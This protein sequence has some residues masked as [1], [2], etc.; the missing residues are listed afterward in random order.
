MTDVIVTKPLTKETED[1]LKAIGLDY[2]CEATQ[3]D[4]RGWMEE[5]GLTAIEIFDLTP[6]V[7]GAWE[8]RRERDLSPEHRQAYSIPLLEDPEL[9]LGE[10]IFY[11]YVRGEKQ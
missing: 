1:A 10:M 7:R 5:A 8:R 6:L 9:G 2:L 11:T 4:F 3:D